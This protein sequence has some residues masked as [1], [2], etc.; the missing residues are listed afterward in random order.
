[1]S[2][3]NRRLLVEILQTVNV[4]EE[5]TAKEFAEVMG[6]SLHLGY[7]PTKTLTH[8]ETASAEPNQ[9]PR[10]LAWTILLRQTRRTFD[11]S[12]ELR[13]VSI[14]ILFILARTSV[15]TTKS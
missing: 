1:M 10:F 4:R 7:D 9:R 6:Q 2:I 11:K 5:D 14:S 15:D 8:V 3:V 13:K 12:L